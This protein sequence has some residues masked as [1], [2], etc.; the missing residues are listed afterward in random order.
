MAS[1]FE[2]G[3]SLLVQIRRKGFRQ[4]TRTFDNTQD[5]R[6]SAEEW[7]E[8]VEHQMK[9]GKYV[10]GSEGERTKLSEA[11][12]RYSREVTPDKKGAKAERNRILALSKIPLAERSLASI[13]ST[14]I[15]K[16]RD[17]KVS[18]GY[19]PSSIRNN[20]TIISQVYNTAITEWGIVG[21]SNPVR[22]LRR[23]KNDPGRER[24]LNNGEEEKILES[25]DQPYKSMFIVAIETAMRR[26]ELCGLLWHDVYLKHRYIVLRDTKN[27]SQRTVPLSTR[28]IHAISDV[29][30]SIDKN[31][32]VFGKKPDSFTHAFK[33]ACKKSAINDLRLH[34]IR[35]E[36]TSR[37]FELGTLDLMEIASITGH[38]DLRM[39]KRYTHLD[40]Q[41][42]AVKL[43]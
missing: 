37:L 13:R 18:D 11:L 4:V 16:Y 21:V 38:K 23:P 30:R 7:A 6:R 27:G 35:H 10:D 40:A 22:G 32:L 43:G 28:A 24:R 3:D 9:F 42:L 5:G 17:E 8:K 2:R 12:L 15:A 33:A 41:K 36:A 25:L 29:P 26:G 14:D 1:Y 31:A 39:L 19:A 34:D 20:L